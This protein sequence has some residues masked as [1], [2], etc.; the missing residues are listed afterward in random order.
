M[1]RGLLI[2]V[3]LIAAG[4]LGYK[5]FIKKDG[6]N[7]P[8]AEPMTVTGSDS[9]TISMAAAL[10]SYYNLKDAFIKS[11][12]S[13]VNQAAGEFVGKLDAVKMEEV[14]A[15]TSLIQLAKQLQQEI[16]RQAGQLAVAQGI[17]PKRKTFQILSD[18]LYDLLRTVRYSGSKV[19]Q[20]FCPMAFDNAGAAWLS[21]STEVVNPY[22]GE[23]MPNCGEVRDSLRTQ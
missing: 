6:G 15:D 5:F 20:Q 9:L 17:E 22:F 14:K 21:N 1:K 10:H 2:L 16:S 23:K 8:K 11:D 3:V 13:L 12:T 18:Q 7:S 4:F 19:Y